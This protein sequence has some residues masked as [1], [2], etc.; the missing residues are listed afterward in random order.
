MAVMLSLQNL[1]SVMISCL[2]EMTVT[3]QL[4]EWN[5]LSTRSKHIISVK[6][7]KV[8]NA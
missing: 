3:G 8:L 5:H 1:A 2:A 6:D 4:E 7:A